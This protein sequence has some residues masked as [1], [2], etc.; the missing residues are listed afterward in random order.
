M[1]D[2]GDGGL[3]IQGVASTLKFFKGPQKLIMKNSQQN[4][5]VIGQTVY[6]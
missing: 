4:I 6:L 1:L 5:N 2:E 3:Y